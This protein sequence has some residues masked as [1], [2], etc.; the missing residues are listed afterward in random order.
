M[1][2][3][4]TKACFLAYF[5]YNRRGYSIHIGDEARLAKICP[6]GLIAS[7]GFRWKLFLVFHWL[8]FSV[9]RLSLAMK[10]VSMPKMNC[11]IL[12][13]LHI[14]RSTVSAWKQ[15]VLRVRGLRPPVLRPEQFGSREPG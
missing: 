12:M 7:T 10:E 5:C 11:A 3:W 9:W 8:L 6:R 1:T 15:P 2:E 4:T 14:A 13:S